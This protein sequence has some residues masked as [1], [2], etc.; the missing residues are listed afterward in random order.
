VCNKIKGKDGMQRVILLTLTC[1]CIHMLTL[2][3]VKA[4]DFVDSV[5][6]LGAK[7]FSHSLHYCGLYLS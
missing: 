2:E 3:S 6:K 1:N 7:S 5:E 4:D